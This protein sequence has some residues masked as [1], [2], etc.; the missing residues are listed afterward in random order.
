MLHRVRKL[1]GVFCAL[2]LFLPAGAQAAWTLRETVSTSAVFAGDEVELDVGTDGTGALAWIKSGPGTSRGRLAVAMRAPNG[3]FG[4]PADLSTDGE[5]VEDAAVAV[6]PRGEAIAVWS[7]AAIGIRAVEA[8]FRPPGGTFGPRRRLAGYQPDVGIVAAGFDRDGNASL[9]WRDKVQGSDGSYRYRWDSAIRRVDGV[10]VENASADAGTE[11]SRE[12]AFAFGPD[13][14]AVVAFDEARFITAMVRPGLTGAFG[15]MQPLSRINEGHAPRLAARPDGGTVLLFTHLKDGTSSSN[16]AERPPGGVFGAARELRAPAGFEDVAVDGRGHAMVAG[17][18]ADA[19]LPTERVLRFRERLPGSVWSEDRVALPDVDFD[20][21]TVLA[22]DATG[23][24]FLAGIAPD[25]LTG[26]PTVRATSATPAGVWEQAQTVARAD[27]RRGGLGPVS[28]AA[29]PAGQ[30]VV[31]YMAYENDSWTVQASRWTPD[32]PPGEPET[33]PLPTPPPAQAHS[34]QVDAD[35]AR[36]GRLAGAGVAPPLARA[37][38]STTR[39]TPYH[40]VTGDG[41][42]YVLRRPSLDEPLRA[43]ALD[44]VDGRELWRSPALDMSD[45][46]TGG[47]LAFADGRVFA[48][49][50]GKIAA[51]S[52]STGAVLWTQLLRQFS[53]TEP[54]VMGDT[55]VARSSFRGSSI[56]AFE[57]ASGAV[58]WSTWSEDGRLIGAEGQVIASAG[59]R[60]SMSRDLRSGEVL[61]IQDEGDGCEGYGD[62]YDGDWLWTD[63]RIIDVSDGRLVRRVPGSAP[64]LAGATGVQLRSGGLEGIDLA[65]RVRRWR[66][67]QPAGE[68]IVVEPLV[69]DGLAYVVTDAG[70]VVAVDPETGTTRW[71]GS[72]GEPVPDDGPYALSAGFGAL[73]VPV[74]GGVI[75]L[76]AAPG[77]PADP[78]TPV[79]SDPADQQP[80][81]PRPATEDD[82]ETAVVVASAPAGASGPAVPDRRG[83]ASGSAPSG[84]GDAALRIGVRVPAGQ[85]LQTVLRRGLRLTATCSQTC[86]LSW[87]ATAVR[88]KRPTSTLGRRSGTVAGPAARIRSASIR[89]PAAAA[90]AL[91]R[92]TPVELTVLIEGRDAH[93]RRA[94]TRV[95]VSLGVRRGR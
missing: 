93:G 52:A 30:A 45:E 61:W 36:T 94:T 41:R 59:C 70:T 77:P 42:V 63:G 8:S 69:V 55:V 29:G 23:S 32:A 85:R 65:T 34:S 78:P 20:D 5:A 86:R 62:T 43:F 49:V 33:R 66:T 54:L 10:W 22:R 76:R 88:W 50:G 68:K 40:V 9:V 19:S 79:A 82:G 1:I 39:P 11:H 44:P 84:S 28:I 25:P 31:A 80:A 35:A 14:S 18:G 21:G 6:G 47:K 73:L 57:A 48:T 81:E 12:P 67:E 95:R 7:W 4:E 26:V 90:R 2:A 83:T 71:S 92:G 13:G 46:L 89:V 38:R 51:L 56:D 60:G 75:A 58:R 24:A 27:P 15:A 3:D 72:V 17:S 74:A 91:L 16:I 87:R 53:S 64:A 37:W